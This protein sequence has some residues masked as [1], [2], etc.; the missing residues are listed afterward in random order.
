MNK[1]LAKYVVE[2]FVV[3]TGVLIS[4]YVEKHRATA[5]RDELKNHSLARLASN[6]K[7]DISAVGSTTGFTPR[8]PKRV[9]SSLRTTMNFASITEIPSAII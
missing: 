3:V 5:Y 1:Y 2:F 8:R 6:V 9:K 4:F 7:A